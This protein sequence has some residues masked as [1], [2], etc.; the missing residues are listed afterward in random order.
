[1]S[2]GLKPS[3]DQRPSPLQ[4]RSNEI[5]RLVGGLAQG[6]PELG[7]LAVGGYGRAELSLHSDIDLLFLHEGPAPE[8][9]IRSILYPL[10]DARHK[11]GHATRTVR[12][13]LAFARDDLAALC[14]L[15]SARL[16]SGPPSLFD[17]VLAGLAKLL[18]G[19]RA[20]LPELL[21]AEE[22]RVW[23][24]EPFARQELDLKSGRGGLRSHHRLEW[25]RKRSR[26]IGEEPILPAGQTERT[27]VATLLQVRE[28]L[29]AVQ[30]RAADLYPVE[31]RSQIGEKLG[32]DP[33]DLATEVYGAARTID[34]TAALRWGRVRPAG[35]DPINHAGL[36]VIRLVRSRWGKREPAATPF[37]YARAAAASGSGGRLSLWE[38]DFVARMGPP[39]WHSGDRSSLLA[40][41]ADGTSGWQALLGLWEAGWLTRALPEL[42]H[43]RGLA[44]VAPFH[45]HP[46]DA[47]LG[48]TVA[49]VVDLAEGAID[50]CG[51][52]ADQMGGLDELLLAAFLHDIG[53][54]LP[55]DHS[56]T[57]SA[58]A[59]KLLI[60]IGFSLTTAGVVGDAVRH[61]LLLPETAFRR[62]TEDPAVIGLLAASVGSL[63]FLR[64]LTLLSVADARAT[65][66][67]M[68]S[69]W[70][71]SLLRA[72]VTRT[73]AV[74][75]GRQTSVPEAVVDELAVLVPEIGP[76]SIAAHL[77]GMPPD[78]LGRFGTEVVATHLRLSHPDLGAAEVRTAVVP[79]APVSN[80][81]VAA[82]DRP[83]LLA[84][85]AGVL[86]VH[87]LNVLEA[88]V[89]TRND[90]L[91]IDTFRVADSRGSDMVGQGRWP[92]V[93]ETLERTVA[94]TLDLEARLAEKRVA[95]LHMNPRS[96]EVRITDATIDI[97]TGDRVGLLHDLALAMTSLGLSI[98]LAKIDT[99]R[100]E[101]IDVFEVTRPAHIADEVI[102]RSLT[103]AVLG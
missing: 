47:H 54:G 36:A 72:L 103:A 53:K 37:A 28:A 20:N 41:L 50:W 42:G 56:V 55:G 33:S 6:H 68:W 1:V 73:A 75:E 23:E 102:E 61:H 26:L 62:D 17:E 10:W 38:R 4:A 31:L 27:A 90:G 7:V 45:Q 19:A 35:T 8:E 57:G 32:R 69:P 81:V 24:R 64:L 98:T 15:L 51:E 82:R 60:R 97:R 95:P 48:A 44:Q 91:A 58:L 99:R 49:N 66:A 94:G 52:I 29:H 71:E 63:D 14:S 22:H 101:A 25:D 87:N 89:V 96:T 40:L 34:G 43:L 85:V 80:I 5:D 2:E 93:R 59:Q 78:Y 21:A 12:A 39:D 18:T 11:V 92:A 100:G 74:L 16:V 67:D 77:E 13:S 9:A 76:R 70:K 65:G 3:S 88:R 46:V 83:G 84:T 30:R 79:G 86:A